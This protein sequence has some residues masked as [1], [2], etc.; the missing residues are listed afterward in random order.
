VDPDVWIKPTINDS[1]AEYDEYIF[2][3]LR[4]FSSS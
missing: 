1:G 2:V 3:I 4:A